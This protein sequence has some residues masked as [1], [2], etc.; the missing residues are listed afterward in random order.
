[1]NA[2]AGGEG[3]PKRARLTKRS[4][5]L[6]LSREGKRVH[7]SHFIILS[8]VNDAGLGRLGITVTTRIGNAVIRNR[9]KRLVREFFRRHKQMIPAN[10]IVVIAKQGAERLSAGAVAAEIG[11]VLSRDGRRQ[12]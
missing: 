11:G 1:M 4:Q 5:F 6:T 9:V 3:F 8:K 10:D 12:G 7:T 2:A